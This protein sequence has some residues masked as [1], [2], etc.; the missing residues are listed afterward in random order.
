MT[1]AR[2]VPSL[3]GPTERS[4]HLE[5]YYGFRCTCERCEAHGDVSRELDFAD[6]L[7]ARRC[8]RP[9]CGTGLSVPLLCAPARSAPAQSGEVAALVADLDDQVDVA[10]SSEEE[11]EGLLALRCMHCGETWLQE[12]DEWA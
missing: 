4:D 11:D 2:C 12:I 6:R 3:A 1:L 9:V 8:T 10:A 7:E 5:E